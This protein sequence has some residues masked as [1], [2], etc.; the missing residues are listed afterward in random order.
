MQSV[1]FVSWAHIYFSNWLAYTSHSAYDAT[2]TELD[3]VKI[4]GFLYPNFMNPLI[5]INSVRFGLCCIIV[6][7]AYWFSDWANFLSAWNLKTISAAMLHKVHK[8]LWD[9]IQARWYLW[10]R[11]LSCLVSYIFHK[12]Q[13]LLSKNKRGIQPPPNVEPRK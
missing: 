8:E 9:A 7:S 3:K 6:S 2:L 13:R 12:D 11:K 10:K 4:N 5:L 1:Y